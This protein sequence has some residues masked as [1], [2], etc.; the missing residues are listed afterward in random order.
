MALIYPSRKKSITDESNAVNT[1]T[2]KKITKAQIGT[3]STII[4]E[5]RLDQ[6]PQN[7]NNR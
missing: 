5:K 2:K 4:I 6:S 3:I 7:H 1:Q